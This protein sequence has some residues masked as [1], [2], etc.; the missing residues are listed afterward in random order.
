[1]SKI[2]LSKLETA[3]L[4][5][6]SA[7]PDTSSSLF[8]DVRYDRVYYELA[9]YNGVYTVTKF[10]EARSPIS[11][12]TPTFN[13]TT[14]SFIPLVVGNAFGID[15]DPVKPPMLSIADVNLSH[16]RTSADLE[17]GRHIVGLPQPIITGAE[18]DKPLYVGSSKA[19]T[20]PNEKAK[21]YYLEF[22]GQGLDGLARALKEKE[23]QMANFS[24]QLQDKSTRGSEA[25]GTVRLRYSSD[26]ASLVEVAS[27]VEAM[28]NK[29]YG[30][31]AA[32]S[33]Y[34][35][36][37]IELNKDLL[38]GKLSAQDITALTKSWLDGALTDEQLMYNLRRGEIIPPPQ[39]IGGDSDVT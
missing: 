12:Q 4:G 14:L 26:A 25:E 30:I 33:E 17:T 23:D 6:E 13:G 37:N 38:S 1:V 34:D 22:R 31:I 28:L 8:E 11:R 20:L 10:D 35:T 19:W 2:L 9:V 29:V 21:A 18:S 24:A 27:S 36:P 15:I 16:Y 5:A 39:T 7:Q 3:R 32:W